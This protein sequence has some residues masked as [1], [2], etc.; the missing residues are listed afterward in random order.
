M[1]KKNIENIKNSCNKTKITPIS[2]ETQHHM[3]DCK[4]KQALSNSS[5][6]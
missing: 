6:Q 1:E 2:I 5:S 4:T 3:S